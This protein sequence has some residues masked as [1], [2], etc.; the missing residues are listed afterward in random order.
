[1]LKYGFKTW[2]KIIT[3]WMVLFLYCCSGFEFSP[4]D[5]YIPRDIRNSNEKNIQ[6][7]KSLELGNEYH[8]AVISDVHTSYDELDDCIKN[9]N[10]QDDIA[11][12]II[13]GDLTHSGHKDEYLQLYNLLAGFNMP[14]LAVIG[15]HDYFNNGGDVFRQLFGSVNYTFNIQNTKYI[16]FDSN[17]GA[18]GYNVHPE[19]LLSIASDT[20]NTNRALLFAHIAP[21]S[22]INPE[23]S[24][25]KNEYLEVFELPLLC[26]SFFGHEHYFSLYEIPLICYT[27]C[28]EHHNYTLVSIT[29]QGININRIY[30]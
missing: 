16:F 30:F 23:D 20:V 3:L 24:A 10:K 7:I 1:M 6:K 21:W 29:A 11:F 26:C 4:Y 14:V 12:V 19:W 22:F 2:I 25:L 17:F 5:T 18:D 27:D 28:I 15:N 8:F 9:I 13:T